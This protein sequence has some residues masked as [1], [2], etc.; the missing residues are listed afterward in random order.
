VACE[1]RGYQLQHQL[2]PLVAINFGIFEKF[3]HILNSN[4]LGA[5][6]VPA[7]DAQQ[8]LGVAKHRK[9]VNTFA[10]NLSN[11]DNLIAAQRWGISPSRRCGHAASLEMWLNRVLGFA[12]RSEAVAPSATASQR[13]CRLCEAV[14]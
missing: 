10:S 9:Y 8:R 3:G 12:A 7:L 13:L 14:A 5:L 4:A 1:R 2:P 11:R 6:S